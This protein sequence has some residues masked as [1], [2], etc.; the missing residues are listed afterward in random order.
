MHKALANLAGLDGLF[1]LNLDSDAVLPRDALSPLAGLPHLGWLGC[2]GGHIDDDAMRQI[3]A[4]PR[5]RFLMC[6]D[7][8]AG[9][10]GFAALS[11]S[12]TIEHIW[13]RRCHNLR[14]RG[15]ARW[16]RCRP[17]TPCP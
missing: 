6:Q 10:E 13:G 1:G 3:G 17:F 5:L 8:V 15:F 14:S 16:R 4:M 12:Q 11:R 7:T 9:D 2:G